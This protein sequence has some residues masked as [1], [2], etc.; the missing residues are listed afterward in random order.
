MYVCKY[1]RYI[2]T[3]ITAKNNV[4]NIPVDI[5]FVYNQLSFICFLKIFILKTFS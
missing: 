2:C 3:D 4:M 5:L 1:V